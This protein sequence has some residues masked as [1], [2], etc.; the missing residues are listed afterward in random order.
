MPSP[1]G[2]ASVFL[3]T[4]CPGSA[5]TTSRGSCKGRSRARD[6]RP[7][8]GSVGIDRPLSTLALQ[9]SQAHAAGKCEPIGWRLS[10]ARSP[11]APRKALR[12]LKSER[13][14]SYWVAPFLRTST[15]QATLVQIRQT[16]RALQRELANNGAIR[17]QYSHLSRRFDEAESA[18]NL[19][20]EDTIQFIAA[21]FTRRGDQ[22]GECERALF[23]VPLQSHGSREQACG[24]KSFFRS[25]RI[26]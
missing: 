21:E 13:S 14:L 1:R 8:P 26:S 16:A 6:E 12:P 5:Y 2:G 24:P 19:A 15:E 9:A 11:E 22:F 20:G 7:R 4:L 18:S 25:K 10:R 23:C 17:E 3:P